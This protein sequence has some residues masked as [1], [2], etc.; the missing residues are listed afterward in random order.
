MF[1]N[2]KKKHLL[3][4]NIK[5]ACMLYVYFAVIQ[6]NKAIH[7]MSKHLLKIILQKEI[8]IICFDVKIKS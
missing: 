8:S 2:N 5:Y 7:R 6:S 4:Y 3:Y 1:Q